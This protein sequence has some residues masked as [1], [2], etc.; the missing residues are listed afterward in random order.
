[1]QKKCLSE[2]INENNNEKDPTKQF[3]NFNSKQ[4]EEH[5]NRLK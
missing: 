4:K 2:N 5:K 3:E 1:M